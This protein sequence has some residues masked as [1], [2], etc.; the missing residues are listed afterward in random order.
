MIIFTLEA[1]F[2]D[3]QKI[4]LRTWM[5]HWLLATCTLTGET[6]DPQHLSSSAALTFLLSLPHTPSFPVISYNKGSSRCSLKLPHIVSQFK[7]FLV[8]YAKGQ[9]CGRGMREKIF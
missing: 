8:P 3:V 5:L 6:A 7:M 2:R 9:L 1:S 4:L